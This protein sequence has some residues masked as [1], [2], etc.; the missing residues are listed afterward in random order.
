MA[1]VFMNVGATWINI[2]DTVGYWGQTIWLYSIPS[3][4]TLGL[5]MKLE[6]VIPK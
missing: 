5:D 4:W 2:G 1:V 3:S 6:F